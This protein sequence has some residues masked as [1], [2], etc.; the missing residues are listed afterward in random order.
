MRIINVPGRGIG[1]RTLDDLTKWAVSQGISIYEAL[2][3]LALPGLVTTGLPFSSRVA[4]TLGSFGSLIKELITARNEMGLLDF[5]DQVATRSGYKD[6]LLNE[7]D[8]DERWD[9]VQEL[10]TVAEQYRDLPTGE[11]LSSFLEGVAL[12]SDVDELKEQ[13]DRVTLITL[14]QAKGLEFDIVFI[15]GVEEGLLPHFRTFDD[16]SQMEEER[17]L[18]YVGITRARKKIYLVHAFR[19]NLMGKSTVNKAS[20]FL[21]DIPRNLVAGGD[22]WKAEESR[23]GSDF[24]AGISPLAG[25]KGP[26]SQAPLPDLKSGDRVHHIQF[27]EGVVVSCNPKGNDSEVVVAFNGV[28][29]KKLLL[30]FARLEKAG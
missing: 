26:V 27:G 3:R 5:F 22:L 25:R 4:K 20:R 2:Q 30:S 8:G 28:G 6:Y 24:S 15:V 13:S 14:H 10:R 7:E 29:V 23:I 18:C 11:A 21:Q 9:N 12:V 16:P 1:Q 17:R 19:R